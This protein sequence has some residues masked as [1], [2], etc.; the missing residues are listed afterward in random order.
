MTEG[1]FVVLREGA[2]I[3]SSREVGGAEAVVE[4]TDMVAAIYSQMRVGG[5]E[6]ALWE[7]WPPCWS[8]FGDTSAKL[9]L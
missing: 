6:G 8:W 1:A 4:G 2:V 9:F 3:F 5:V 7:R